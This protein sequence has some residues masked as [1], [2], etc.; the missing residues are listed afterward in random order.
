M[1]M[2]IVRCRHIGAIRMVQHGLDHIGRHAQLGCVGG[3]R[4]LQ[5]VARKRPN[6]AIDY[7]FVIM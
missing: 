5:I 2:H 4:A 7:A 6:L 1:Q 3:K